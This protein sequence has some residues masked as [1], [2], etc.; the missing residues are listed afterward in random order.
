MR[1]LQAL[2]E[3]DAYPHPCEAIE[4]VETHISWVFLTGS[5]AYKIKKPVDFGFVDF[6]TLG[7]RRFFCFEEIRCN[8]LFAPEIYLDV[9]PI[10]EDGC[11][12]YRIEGK[13]RVV[14]Y[15][16]KMRQF[17]QAAQLDRLLERGEL[18]AKTLRDFAVSLASIYENI[19]AIKTKSVKDSTRLT[20]QAIGDNFSVLTQ[21]EGAR[22]WRTVLERIE[23]WSIENATRLD[24]VFRERR[25]DGF[26]R[27]LH[28]DLHLS[29]LFLS[30]KGA[31]AF[32]C[33]EF[34]RELREIDVASDVAFLFMDCA[35]RE[36]PD[37]A[38]DFID[39]YLDISGDY[40]IAIM[41]R[42]Y[43]VYR[44]MVRA[45]VAGLGLA[46]AES[47]AL[48]SKLTNHIAWAEKVIRP[49]EQRIIVMC[50]LSGSGKSWLASRL[51]PRLQAIRLRSDR[52]R[53]T[54]AG[55]NRS[56][57]SE[58]SLG[59]G[60]YTSTMSDK[61]YM[62]LLDLTQ[63]I[64]RS[65]ETVIVDGTFLSRDHRDSFHRMAEQ[66][67][68]PLVVVECVAST[69]ILRQ[70]ISKRRDKGDDPSEATL[71]VLDHQIAIYCVPGTNE[72]L[73]RVRTEGETDIDDV[74]KQIV[75]ATSH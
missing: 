7:K 41:L 64:L 70:R 6:S 20:N 35:V 10:V 30:E 50:G 19:P 54:L 15:A 3:A 4:M 59:S 53:R 1:V 65:G 74:A 27:S 8:R 55:L 31:R 68:C 5:Y 21:L 48:R 42:Y 16:V 46:Q 23:R 22:S 43:A 25:R 56:A 24:S 39:S 26:I 58:S 57:S 29:N 75:A 28:G 47:A 45:K 17:D 49:P 63:A 9:V 71:N 60:I 18:D 44:S 36:R 13:G 69:E 52:L 67:N 14:E 34:S 37:L 38:Y 73:V 11:G 72:N 33:I 51:V 66:M 32:D 12:A 2:R 40:T 61:V 62:A